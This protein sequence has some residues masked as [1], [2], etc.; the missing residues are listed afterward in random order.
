MPYIQCPDGNIY[1]RYDNSPY[2]VE[3][4]AGEAK[5]NDSI[6]NACTLD[7]DCLKER[8]ASHQRVSWV[9]NGICISM[10]LLIFL[11]FLKAKE[12]R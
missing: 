12:K 1:S 6:Y 2:V 5:R 10:L 3:C 9:I 8:Q 4:I 11:I 7:P